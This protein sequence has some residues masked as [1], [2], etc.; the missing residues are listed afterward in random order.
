ML[1]EADRVFYN[2]DQN[3]ET[4]DHVKDSMDE[5]RISV[6]GEEEKTEE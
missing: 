2:L 6:E 3:I 5:D 1:K 4:I